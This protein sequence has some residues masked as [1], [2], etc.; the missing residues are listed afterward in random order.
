MRI[1]RVDAQVRL[2]TRR[3]LVAYAAVAP[4]KVQNMIL[5]GGVIRSG[6]RTSLVMWI[7]LIGTWGFGVPLACL[8]AFVWGLPIHWVYFLLSLEE[9]VRLAISLWVFHSRRWMRQLEE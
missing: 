2:L 3:I 6:G 5:G 4:L 8:S 1:F 7:D 9:G